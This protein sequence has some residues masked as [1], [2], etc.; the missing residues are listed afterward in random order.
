MARARTHKDVEFQ[1]YSGENDP[2]E[3]MFK[4]ADKAFAAVGF[5]CVT[6]GEATLDV[7]VWSRAGARW[8]GGD[9]AVEQYDEDPEAS[10]FER[11]EFRCNALGR[12]P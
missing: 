1:V 2:R 7:I 4:E 10:I 12:V 3:E 8:Y 5:R 6:S 9:S 11:F